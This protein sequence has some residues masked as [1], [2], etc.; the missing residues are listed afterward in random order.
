MKLEAARDNL[1]NSRQLQSALQPNGII[2]EITVLKSEVKE[3]KDTV[4]NLIKM[5]GGSISSQEDAYLQ[6]KTSLQ[7]K[8]RVSKILQ[9]HFI[10]MNL[11]AA[12]WERDW[13]DLGIS[14]NAVFNGNG[15]DEQ[16]RLIIG[17]W[18]MGRFNKYTN[19]VKNKVYE[20]NN[21]EWRTMDK[22]DYALTA[23]LS[24][25]DNI[26]KTENVSW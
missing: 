15:K 14:Y 6:Q 2:D 26:S 13:F 12:Y 11:A 4:V 18:Y 22:Q 1:V 7:Q 16:G 21:E 23:T 5:R 3:L 24:L 17:P 20:A 10:K 19:Y 25:G 8:E 9:D